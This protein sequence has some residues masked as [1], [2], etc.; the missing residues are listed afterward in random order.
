MS[1]IRKVRKWL[2]REHHIARTMRSSVIV[3]SVLA[4]LRGSCERP[5]P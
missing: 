3:R 5:S 2:A 1:Q 4:S